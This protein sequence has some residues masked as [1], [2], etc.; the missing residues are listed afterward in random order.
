MVNDKTL[1]VRDG[2]LD[3][4]NRIDFNSTLIRVDNYTGER[5]QSHISAKL[6]TPEELIHQPYGGIKPKKKEE[7]ER[8]V[9]EAFEKAQAII[10]SGLV[11]SFIEG[12]TEGKIETATF[13]LKDGENPEKVAK[14]TG[15]QLEQIY[16]LQPA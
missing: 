3:A 13:M 7:E 6:P 5:Y 12:K 10:D 16:Q 2:W 8:N 4:I 1:R 11:S 9:A 14:Y 15:L